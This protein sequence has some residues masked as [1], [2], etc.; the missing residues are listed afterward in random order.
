M[1]DTITSQ[2]I[3]LSSWIT[4]WVCVCIR[5]RACAYVRLRVFTRSHARMYTRRHTYG[6]NQEKHPTFFL[7]MT[8][9]RTSQTTYPSSWITL[10]M[11]LSGEFSISDLRVHIS[12]ESEFPK[13]YD[14]LI[15]LF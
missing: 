11:D 14:K 7:T 10:Y 4:L 5:A 8:D 12:L 3:D 15:S 2:N 6:M 9:T 1:T 13:R